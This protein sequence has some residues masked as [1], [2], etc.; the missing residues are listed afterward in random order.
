V[1][2]VDQ[3]FTP[4]ADIDGVRSKALIVG[5]VGLIACAVGFVI[6]RDQFFRAWL[7]S[8]WLFLGIALGSLALMMVQ[9]LTGGTWGVFRR[10]FE[11]AS[12][13]LPLLA[14]LFIPLLFGL[15]TLYPWANPAL[16]QA[17]E[18][19]QHRAPYL[20]TTLWIARAVFYLGG[21]IVLSVVLNRLS[22]RQDD[23]EHAVNLTIQRLS[24]FGLVFYGLTTTLAAIDW[25]MALNPHWYSTMFGFLTMAGQGLSGL[26]FTIVAGKFLLGRAPMAGFLKPRDFHDLG[27]LML[28]FVMLW[29]YFNFSQYLLTYAANL[30]EEVPYTI[31][32]ISNG[33]EYLALALVVFH[34]AAPF[35]LLLSRDLK[36]MP[37]RLVKLAIWLLIMRLADIIMLVSPEF[38]SSGPNLHIEAGEHVSHFFLHWMD[39]AAP[40]GIGGVWVWMF[41]T[42]LKQRPL[43]AIGDPYLRESLETVTGGH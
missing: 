21:W 41:Y 6:D 37:H 15:R 33:W 4:P 16:V 5:V 8:Y 27:K 1:D 14:V 40:L 13:T 38:A 18:I 28:A 10:I 9:H 25:L 35:L 31:T 20:N 24:G 32:R 42:Q 23:G 7:I 3:T 19:L 29:A 12:R 43:L 34:F 22:R 30:V 26:A 36:R 17:D 39:L 11:A 2:I